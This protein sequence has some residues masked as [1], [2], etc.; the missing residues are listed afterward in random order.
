MPVEACALDCLLITLLEGLRKPQSFVIGKL[1]RKDA[2][3]FYL[4][5]VTELLIIAAEYLNTTTMNTEGGLIRPEK[6]LLKPETVET[7][8]SGKKKSFV[9]LTFKSEKKIRQLFKQIMTAYI[10][11]LAYFRCPTWTSF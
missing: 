4:S 11:S 2:E 6:G 5:K 3:D 1:T 9:S 7:F 8:V 10:V